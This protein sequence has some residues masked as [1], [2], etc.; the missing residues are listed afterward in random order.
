MREDKRNENIFTSSET[1]LM[2]NKH[3]VERSSY[4]E[5]HLSGVKMFVFALL[6]K[7]E[8]IKARSGDGAEDGIQM[9]V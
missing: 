9:S 4:V 8:N 3:N 5:H 2:N 7:L 6:M 1:S